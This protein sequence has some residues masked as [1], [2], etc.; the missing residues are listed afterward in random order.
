MIGLEGSLW[1]VGHG[2]EIELGRR[3]AIMAIIN[4]TPDSFS[5]GGRFKT[6]DAAVEHALQA[7]SDGAAIVD[8]GGES[9][10]PGAAPVSPSEEQA[11][12]LP[13]IEALR[14]RTQALISIDTYRVETAQLAVSAG[15][16]IVNDVSGLQKESGIAEL[17]AATGAGLCIMHTGRDRVKLADVIADQVHFLERSLAIAAAAGVNGDRIVLD[18]GFGFAKETAEEN[19][20]LMARFSE[21]SRFG[22]PLLAGTSRKRFLG[23]VTGREAADRDVATAATSALLRLQGAAVFRVHNVAIN[24][25][26]LDVADAMLNARQKF[27]RKRPT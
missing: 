25:A 8:I 5:D 9:T 12:V 26:A 16:H 10:R 13:V 3:S 7:V 21:L 14:G 17:A 11:R 6:V 23:T 2:R 24:R 19:L 4:V 27:E 22:L 20:E 15:A 18:P 1:R